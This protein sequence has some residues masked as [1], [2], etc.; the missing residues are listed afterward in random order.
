LLELRDK[1]FKESRRVLLELFGSTRFGWDF[2]ASGASNFGAL[3]A[4]ASVFG[5]GADGGG[6]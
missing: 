5:A 4:E 3:F 6:G 2:G 1:L